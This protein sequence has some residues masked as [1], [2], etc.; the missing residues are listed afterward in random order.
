MRWLW[1]LPLTNPTSDTRRTD[2]TV[3]LLF[4][5]I[6]DSTGLTVGPATGAGWRCSAPTTR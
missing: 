6:E 2:G 4:T 1:P 5:D 3:T